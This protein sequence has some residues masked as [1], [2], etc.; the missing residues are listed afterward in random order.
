MTNAQSNIDQLYYDGGCPLCQR[1]ISALKRL[2]DSQLR[3]TDLLTLPAQE[4]AQHPAR[5]TLMPDAT[6]AECSAGE[7][8]DCLP[9]GVCDM[10]RRPCVDGSWG[11]TCEDVVNG[12]RP[13]VCTPDL[14]DEDCDGS[15][16]ITSVD[17]QQL[18][19]VFVSP[20]PFQERFTI[21]NESNNKLQYRLYT[22]QGREIKQGSLTKQS[23]LSI[24]QESAGLYFLRVEDEQ[25]RGKVFRL[26][27]L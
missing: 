15:D 21:V 19:D 23:I 2:A 27:N 22:S 20:N 8:L 26:V 11:A 7:T 14:I 5:D 3:F 24:E 25:G 1:E 6:S 12:G 13:E 4:T 9:V 17:N 10:R 18:S 16:L